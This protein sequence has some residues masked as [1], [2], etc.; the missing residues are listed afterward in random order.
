M[1]AW[2][3]I[4]RELRYRRLN[5]WL[6]V[7][8]VAI[9]A[10]CVVAALSLVDR[11]RQRS[12]IRAEAEKI[13]LQHRMDELNDDFR[14]INLGL[15]FN[16]RILPK[17]QNLA[18][19]YADDFAAKMM[20][21]SYAQKLAQAKLASINHI[22]PILKQ[23]VAWPEQSRTIQLFG[24]RGEVVLGAGSRKSALQAPVLPGNVVVGHEL[25]KNLNLAIGQQL[26]FQG[27]TW[28]VSG[29]Q[30]QRGNE[31]DI[32]LWINLAEAQDLL[33]KPGQISAILALECNC[34]ADRLATIRGEIAR[35]LP[36]TQVVEFASQ[37]IAR[38]ENRSRGEAEAKEAVERQEESRTAELHQRERLFSLLLPV[39]IGACGVWAA[40]LAW[41]N[42]RQRR[43]EIGIL[44]ALG[45]PGWR[46]LAIF[47]GRALLIG[48]AGG[49]VGFCSG[50]VGSWLGEQHL[51]RETALGPQFS[52]AL[53]AAVL[54]AAAFFSAIAGFLPAVRAA[55][56][57]PVEC[58]H[59]T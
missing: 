21:D 24:T 15:G 17:D 25:H 4:F 50:W 42:V 46:V 28:K 26:T 34:V 58:L 31:E 37:A 11:F 2:H 8:S 59:S 54:L 45:A 56:L 32:T 12:Q 10:A 9:A 48:L 57:D 20:P 7:A 27:R 3:V 36:D 47:V 49:A 16:L 40:V 29:L 13:S 43:A 23:R 55:Q 5:F 18:D 51:S 6:A 30:P 22:L 14:K 53:C 52:P 35:V 19:F 38:A 33:K 1:N 39:V 41:M 44:R